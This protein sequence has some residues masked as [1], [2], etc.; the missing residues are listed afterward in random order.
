MAHRFT[1][2]V[3]LIWSGLLI[4]MGNF[5]FVYTFAALACA[6]RFAHV[7]LFGIN[8]VPLAS[9]ASSILSASAIVAMMWT[10]VRRLRG[11]SSADAHSRFIYL[12][13]LGAGGLALIALAW[14]ALPPWLSDVGC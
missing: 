12:V 10:A 3:F 8:I 7:E 1:P 6:W 5:L 2:T 11:E 13:T 14:V 4:W 9:S